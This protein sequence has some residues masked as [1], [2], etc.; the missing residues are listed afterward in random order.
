MNRTRIIIITVVAFFAI[1]ISGYTVFSATTNKT[2]LA[3]KI[4]LK[5]NNKIEKADA[6]TDSD[7]VSVKDAWKFPSEKKD[8]PNLDQHK[9]AFLRVSLDDQKVYIMDGNQVL[10]TMNAAT[11]EKKSAT[12]KGTFEIQNRGDHFYNASSDEGAN[13]WTSFKD[14]GVYLFHTVPTDKAGN[15][16]ES[17]AEKLGTPSSHGCV[18]LTIPDAKW[19]NSKVPSGMKVVVE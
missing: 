2:N 11:G 17:E 5:D 7:S 14:W 10:Y 8:Y 1:A 12:P 3:S 19:I 15:Y 9:D 16:V 6:A 13:Y 4:E 18:R